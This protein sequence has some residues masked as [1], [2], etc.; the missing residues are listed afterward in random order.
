[1]RIAILGAGSLGTVAGAYIAAGG[2]E[3]ELIDVYQAHVDALN[4]SGAKI[5][6]TTD[7]QAK[8]KAVTPDNMSGVYD[9]V[10]LLTKQLHNDSVLR[11]L[12]PFLHD[13]SVVLSL[14]NGIPEE[15]VASIV[16]R[17]RVIAGSVEFGATFMEP[18]VSKLTTEH[19]H[20]KKYA[21]QIGE[22][23]GSTTQRLQQIQAILN[24][25]GGT[26]ISDNLVGTKWSKLLI[27]NAF[28]GLSAALNTTFGGV[29]DHEI[30]LISAAHIADETIKVGHAN[31]VQFAAMN[32]FDPASLELNR[33]EDISPSTQKLL[34][35]M[36]ASRLLK[37]SMLQDLEKK[38]KTEIDCINGVIPRL[39]AGKDILTPYNDLV[40]QL[41]KQ[42]EETQSVPEFEVN[43]QR[44]AE[45]NRR[46]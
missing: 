35:L 30:S 38:R 9:L 40:V 24:L 25:V 41:V 4:Q 46:G 16:G 34:Q 27:N 44:L 23:D 15:K 17:E 8:V 33:E 6:G 31:G 18:G 12:L 43:I 20:F 7:F 39:A 2:Q 19:R 11:D 42:A 14:Q 37:A 1:M 36:K 3:V 10:L 21:F 5:V 26:H 28:S 29:L 45:L 13:Q 22:L 32:G